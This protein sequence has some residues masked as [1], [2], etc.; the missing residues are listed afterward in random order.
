MDDATTGLVESDR[1]TWERFLFGRRRR[2]IVFLALSL[3]YLVTFGPY[4]V[5]DTLASSAAAWN[6][7]TNHTMDFASSGFDRMFWGVEGAG[8]GLIT[9]RFPGTFLIAVPVYWLLP[10]TYVSNGELDQ[11]PYEAGDVLA[12]LLIAGAV[13]VLIEVL[14]ELVEPELALGAGLV[15]GLGTPVWSV[16]SSSL[17]T[18]T[19][20]LLMLAIALRALTSDRLL[21]AGGAL[22]WAVFARPTIAFVAL[23]IGVYLAIARRSVRP[24]LHIGL[25]SLLG[26]VALSVYSHRYFGTWLPAAGYRVDRVPAVLGLGPA[27]LGEFSWREQIVG[28]FLDVDHGVFLYSLFLL[29]LLVAVPAGWRRAPDWTRASAVAGLLYWFMQLRGNR[30]TG[31]AGFIGYRFPLD[32]LW[33]MAPLLVIGSRSWADRSPVFRRVAMATAGVSVAWMVALAITFPSGTP[34]GQPVS[35]R[36]VGGTSGFGPSV[37]ADLVGRHPDGEPGPGQSSVAPSRS[38]N[39]NSCHPVVRYR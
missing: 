28:T 36:I 8:G 1:P 38:T 3:V 10:K 33:L 29:P 21:V 4:H 25:P 12:G 17:W 23:V 16:A 32:P 37:T 18:H 31:G 34:D 6:V 5:T 30:Y 13:V 39:P 22:G 26:A 15:I 20:T 11:V 27:L 9:D 7:A 2:V 19:V 24:V 14:R 35:T